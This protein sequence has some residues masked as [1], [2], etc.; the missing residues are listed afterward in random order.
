MG[1]DSHVPAI[2]AL[3]K[4]IRE[5]GQGQ[6][7][8]F[9]QQAAAADEQRSGSGRVSIE[10]PSLSRLSGKSLCG[11]VTDTAFGSRSAAL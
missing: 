2:V 1:G 3:G 10:F 5:M 9:A 6:W 8:D 4:C 11:S 7:V